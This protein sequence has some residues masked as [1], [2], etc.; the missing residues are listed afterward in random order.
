[1]IG[2]WILPPQSFIAIGN[3][4]LPFFSSQKRP[5]KSIKWGQSQHQVLN[6]TSMANYFSCP[7]FISYPSP[8]TSYCTTRGSLSALLCVC[9]NWWT[10]RRQISLSVSSSLSG[11][12]SRKI[13]RP[14]F[15]PDI[16]RLLSYI[17][18]LQGGYNLQRH[19]PY[20]YLHWF[21]FSLYVW[22]S[23]YGEG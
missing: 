19:A 8:E 6:S 1:M 15:L 12:L 2:C 20:N 13:W 22:W 23:I 4:R 7:T 14:V 21:N 10:V 17:S 18:L 9:V 3:C 16:P 11:G 5:I